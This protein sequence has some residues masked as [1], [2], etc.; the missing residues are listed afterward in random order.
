MGRKKRSAT[1][2]TVDSLQEAKAK[3][4]EQKQS[5]I[6]SQFDQRS[7]KPKH[8]ILGKAQC[9]VDKAAQKRHRAIEIRDQYIFL[10]FFSLGWYGTIIYRFFSP[11]GH[12]DLNWR[13]KKDQMLLTISAWLSLLLLRMP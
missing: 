4:N 13:M 9:R 1:P 12:F 7:I 8:N 5:R 11:L 2:K 3:E 10:F 6:E